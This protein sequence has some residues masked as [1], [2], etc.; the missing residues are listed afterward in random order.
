MDNDL[1]RGLANWIAT[2]HV[3][4]EE[5]ITAA[6]LVII[7]TFAVILAGARSELTEPAVNYLARDTTSGTARILRWPEFHVDRE[8]AAFVNALFGHAIDFD[9]TVS[10]M[11]GHPANIVLSALLAALPEE[12]MSGYDLIRAFVVGHETAVRLGE[13]IGTGHYNRGW[14]TT[15]TIG[16]FGAVAGVAN[17]W[18]LSPEVIVH[19]L[20]IAASMSSGLRVNFG[21]M[22]KPVHSASAA[23]LGLR[24]VSL[25]A[26]GITANAHALFGS[27]GLIEVYGTSASDSRRLLSTLGQ[28][29]VLSSPGVTLKKF[30]CCYATHRTIDALLSMRA[31][32]PAFSPDRV[33]SVVS[34]VA[35][36][37]TRPLPYSRPTTGFEARF[38]MEYILA[39][40]IFDGDFGLSAFTDEAVNRPQI[41]ELMEISAVIEDPECSPGDPLGA[42]M[43]SGTRGHVE[44]VIEFTDG[45]EL[46]R[47]VDVAPGGIGRRLTLSDVLAKFHECAEGGG[48]EAERTLAILKDLESVS[49]VREL[50]AVM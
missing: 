19:A 31:E 15:G 22:T 47:V 3:L 38:S 13:A 5:L 34:R 50:F 28:P 10:S 36:G 2:E 27:Q 39:V 37:V 46:R 16:I 23:S 29:F 44:V 18:R 41:R 21:T 14:H 25:A 48:V 17:L 26:A 12:P 40:G 6:K 7:D 4:D 32:D 20:G 43:S 33:R 35:P 42:T 24:A 49:D 9:D 11:P 1:E 45:S 8:R 30:A